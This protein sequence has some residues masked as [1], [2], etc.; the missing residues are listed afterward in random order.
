MKLKTV[1]AARLLGLLV[2]VSACSLTAYAADP[3][4]DGIKWKDGYPTSLQLVSGKTPISVYGTIDTGK[5]KDMKMTSN[6]AYWEVVEIKGGKEVAGTKKQFKLN[7]YKDSNPQAWDGGSTK[8]IVGGR[9]KDF[10]GFLPG[11]YRITVEVKVKE[12]ANSE[13]RSAILVKEYPIVDPVPGK[14]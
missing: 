3:V 12:T 10:A 4:T 14:E 13:E 9:P 6:V 2:V 1:A 8:E 7:L 11:V 5:Y